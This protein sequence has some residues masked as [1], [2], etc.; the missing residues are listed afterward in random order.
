MRAG[1]MRLL[2]RCDVMRLCRHGRAR[3]AAQRQAKRDEDHHKIT[4]GNNHNAGFMAWA[5]K[6]C[7]ALSS[8][9]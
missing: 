2:L 8:H 5:F 4:H 9:N 3:A 1:L 7:P 6:V